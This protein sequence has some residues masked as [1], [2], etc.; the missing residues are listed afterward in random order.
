[1][2]KDIFESQSLSKFLTAKLDFYVTFIIC[3]KIKNWI[4]GELAGY[5]HD[6]FSCM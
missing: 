6:H 1:M 5:A 2:G 3:K 4:H